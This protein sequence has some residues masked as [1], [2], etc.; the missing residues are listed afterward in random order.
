MSQSLKVREG[1]APTMESTSGTGLMEG[2]KPA[3]LA[4]TTVA[5]QVRFADRAVAGLCLKALSEIPGVLIN[6]VRGR[7]TPKVAEYEIELSG[8]ERLIA[9]V[10]RRLRAASH[11]PEFDSGF[12][13]EGR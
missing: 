10:A 3:S 9:R 4:R 11:L 8:P 6:V 12:L 5:L 1:S 13:M 7:V 2:K